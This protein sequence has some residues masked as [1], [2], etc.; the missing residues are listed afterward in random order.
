MSRPRLARASGSNHGL[1]ASLG[2][3][4]EQKDLARRGGLDGIV[5]NEESSTRS[6]GLLH[7]AIGDTVQDG[8]IPDT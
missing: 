4:K 1:R 2:S 5:V 7:H 6:L 8:D 3:A